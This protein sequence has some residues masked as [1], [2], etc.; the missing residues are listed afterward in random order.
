MVAA[1]LGYRELRRIEFNAYQALG[2]LA[3]LVFMTHITS[4]AYHVLVHLPR[5]LTNSRGLFNFWNQ[6]LTMHGGMVGAGLSLLLVSV[7]SKRSIWQVADAL[8]PASALGLVFFRIGCFSRGCCHGLPCGEDFIFA[9]LTTKLI[10]NME[11]SV[12]PT[13]LYAAAAALFLFIVLWGLRQRKHFEGELIILSLL[14]MSM[15]RFFIEFLRDSHHRMPT[16]FT[17]LSQSL[18]VTQVISLV[19]FVLG[20]SLLGLRWRAFRQGSRRAGMNMRF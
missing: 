8:A 14:F 2:I 3:F 7:L 1:V 13:Q 11:V 18:N 17:F 10:S 15:Q 12:H 9:G 19:F 5:Y 4:H 6:G 16:P 20:L